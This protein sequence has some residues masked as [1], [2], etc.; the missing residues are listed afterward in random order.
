M[1]YYKITENFMIFPTEVF[2]AISQPAIDLIKALTKT[3]PE[4]R[5]SCEGAI[6]HEWL[7]EAVVPAS[8]EAP[9]PA[10]TAKN[11]RESAQRRR[12]SELVDDFAVAAK[13]ASEVAI[14]GVA[15][16]SGIG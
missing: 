13:L 10:A 6:H 9:L 5:L 15:V 14:G 1:L 3:D 2:S 12:S 7:A 16:G 11:R 8:A 4:A